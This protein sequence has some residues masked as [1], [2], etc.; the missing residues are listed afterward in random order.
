MVILMEKLKKEDLGK[1]KTDVDTCI[2]LVKEI[3][4]NYNNKI[5]NAILTPSI[6]NSVNATIGSITKSTKYLEGYY[7]VCD[8]INPITLTDYLLELR[9]YNVDRDVLS[10]YVAFSLKRKINSFYKEIK[11]G[12]LSLGLAMMKDKKGLKNYYNICNDRA[13][14]GLKLLRS[15]I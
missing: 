1:L 14:N 7:I 12:S 2:K 3:S 9:Q 11:N 5:H 10:Y 4:S 13:I 6:I 8:E 15:K